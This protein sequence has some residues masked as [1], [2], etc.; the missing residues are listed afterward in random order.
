[1]SSEKINTMDELDYTGVLGIPGFTKFTQ[2]LGK[3]HSQAEVSG[4]EA[5]SQADAAT[6]SASSTV[7]APDHGSGKV[8]YARLQDVQPAVDY[9]TERSIQAVRASQGRRNLSGPIPAEAVSVALMVVELLG[10]PS[11]AGE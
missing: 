5:I 8:E 2:D 11:K 9:D 1:M 6:A 3:S 7:P 10:D 4:A